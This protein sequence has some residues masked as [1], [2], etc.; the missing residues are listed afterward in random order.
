[1]KNFAQEILARI[2]AVSPER[3]RAVGEFTAEEASDPEG[4]IVF[5]E[6]ITDDI[7][8]ILVVLLEC[9][10]EVSEVHKKIMTV[11]AGNESI[12]V[13]ID[14]YA[15]RLLRVDFEK[16][17]LSAYLKLA[18]RAEYSQYEKIMT[19]DVFKDCKLGYDSEMEEE[20]WEEITTPNDDD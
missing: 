14:T 4:L 5:P 19:L 17:F 15:A 3:L 9:S 20:C 18:L 2:A 8:R 6:L 13:A 1:M 7:K 16:A 11:R 12:Q 10:L